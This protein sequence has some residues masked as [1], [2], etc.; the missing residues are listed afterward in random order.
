MT[1]G[2]RAQLAIDLVFHTA[3]KHE[4]VNMSLLD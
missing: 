2:H 3:A 4:P 1:I